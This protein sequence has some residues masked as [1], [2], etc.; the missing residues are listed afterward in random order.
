M[1]YES[2]DD[3]LADLVKDLG[4]PKRVGPL[5]WPAKD[6]DAAARLLAD[7]F[8]AD[9]PARLSPEQAMFVMRL[10]RQ[11]GK[12]KAIDWLLAELHYAPTRPV[13]P[14]DEVAELQRQMGTLVDAVGAP[15][16]R[17]VEDDA[18]MP[19]TNRARILR[20]ASPGRARTLRELAEASGL[21]VTRTRDTVRNLRREKA[22][23][24]VGE[25][26]EQHRNR[27]VALYVPAEQA[28]GAFS[29]LWSAWCQPLAA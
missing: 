12:H 26:R 16:G 8:N 7:C 29:R 24:I 9:R 6:P 23:R 21:D 11:A 17:H 28:Q 4:G 5:L 2:L 10:G 20:A 25:R 27:P 15:D 19:I 3:A 22:L 18:M 1:T 14:R 13:D